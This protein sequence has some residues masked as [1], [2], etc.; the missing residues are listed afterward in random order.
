MR[1]LPIP[2][3]IQDPMRCQ[4]KHVAVV[5]S[6]LDGTRSQARTQC[7]L[8]RV[9]HPAL[10]QAPAV[11]VS[12]ERH[13]VRVVWIDGERLLRALN[14]SY[15]TFF[16]ELTFKLLSAQDQVISIEIGRRLAH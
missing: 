15:Y 7:R 4:P 13:G 2:S 3:Q 16:G 1:A 14:R 11:A 10:N 6:Q 5:L 9:K 8:L 12:R